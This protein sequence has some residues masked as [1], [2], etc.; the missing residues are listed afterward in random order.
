[1]GMRYT[2]LLAPTTYSCRKHEFKLAGTPSVLPIQPLIHGIGLPCC[3]IACNPGYN[4][5]QFHSQ[6]LGPHYRM[7]KR[8][9]P[10]PVFRQRNG[11]RL[12]LLLLCGLLG[13]PPAQAAQTLAQGGGIMPAAGGKTTAAPRVVAGAPVAPSSKPDVKQTHRSE[14]QAVAM[15]KK[16]LAYMQQYGPDKTIAEVNNPQGP[17]IDGELY[18]FVFDANSEALCLAHGAYPNLVGKDL[19]QLRDPDGVMPAREI[20]R[21]GKSKAGRGWLDYRWPHPVSHKI[22]KKRSYIERSG[23]YIVGAGI[24]RDER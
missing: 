24:T 9:L 7:S 1:M 19:R 8:F 17:F 6:H 12:C 22:E 21:I 2:G 14:Q 5:K 10:V 13:G 15:V 20:M 16:A 23:N 4:W 3:P 11:A 18:V